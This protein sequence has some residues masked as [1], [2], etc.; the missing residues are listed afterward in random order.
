MSEYTVLYW[1]K[2]HDMNGSFAVPLLVA[3]GASWGQ[4]HKVS[5][6]GSFQADQDQV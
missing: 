3:V 1:G 4:A 2:V 6:A 5:E